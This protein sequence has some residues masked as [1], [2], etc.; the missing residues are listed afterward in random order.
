MCVLFVP[1]ALRVNAAGMSGRSLIEWYEELLDLPTEM[2]G[3]G[4]GLLER[5]QVVLRLA[6][7]EYAAV[8]ADQ[9]R[10]EKELRLLQQRHQL[11][12]TK[13]NL[14]GSGRKKAEHRAKNLEGQL[15][16]LQGQLHSEVVA[17]EASESARRLAESDAARHKDL[18]LKATAAWRN[19][20]RIAENKERE[21]VAMEAR[22]R[23]AVEVERRC[24]EPLRCR[25]DD[26]RKSKE[27]DK[28]R[29]LVLR[30]AMEG[31]MAREGRADSAASQVHQQ[32][33][34]LETGPTPHQMVSIVE[35]GRVSG[36]RASGAPA[37]RFSK[38]QLLQAQLH[39]FRSREQG[40]QAWTTTALDL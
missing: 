9:Q 32:R 26:A 4:V 23:T 35:N 20:Q 8:K 28:E 3:E 24:F 18:Y 37:A 7:R 12:V 29:S 27:M 31:L 5:V 30:L 13:A 1:S 2:S 14:E 15:Q 11:L 10:T 22:S 36:A 25:L 38:I 17:R 39:G 6:A 40:R 16:R 34:T 19:A 21:M 33:R